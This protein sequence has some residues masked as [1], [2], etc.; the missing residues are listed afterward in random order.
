MLYAATNVVHTGRWAHGIPCGRGE[1]RDRTS[2]GCGSAIAPL[3]SM[4]D[5]RMTLSTACTNFHEGRV[6]GGLTFPNTPLLE[7]TLIKSPPA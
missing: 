5:D 2:G 3:T 4:A 6:D 7:R 1:R